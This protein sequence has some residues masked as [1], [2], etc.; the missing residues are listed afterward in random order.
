M[1]IASILVIFKLSFDFDMTSL[2]KHILHIYDHETPAFAA[3]LR[4][5]LKI[6]ITNKN[7]EFLF[8]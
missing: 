1:Y 5:I 2:T 6:L 3:E 8:T 4:E 7:I